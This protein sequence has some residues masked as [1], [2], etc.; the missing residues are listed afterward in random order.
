MLTHKRLL[1]LIDY[2]PETGIAFWKITRGG[3]RAGGRVGTIAHGSKRS[4]P[5]RYFA[6]A[7]HGPRKIPFSH[8]VNFYMT[9]RWP[10]AEMDHVH[11]DTLDDRWLELRPSTREQNEA[12]R[13]ARRHNKLGIKGVWRRKDGKYRSAIH[14]RGKRE[15]LG[16]FDTERAAAAAYLAKA[17]AFD[18]KFMR[19]A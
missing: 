1:E 18:G 6:C 5:Y 7:E 17:K 13:G 14:R 4:K 19:V 15:D 9:G 11:G 2:N 3:R 16:I 10:K 12:N 8:M